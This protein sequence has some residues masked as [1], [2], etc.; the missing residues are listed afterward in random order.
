MITTGVCVWSGTETLKRQKK[1]EVVKTLI[2]RPVCSTNQGLVVEVCLCVSGCANVGASGGSFWGEIWEMQKEC[3]CTSVWRSG[4]CG[5][6]V[7]FPSHPAARDDACDVIVSGNKWEKTAQ[8]LI[9]Y[10]IHVVVTNR[11][12]NCLTRGI[13]ITNA[14]F[15]Y[16]SRSG[17]EGRMSCPCRPSFLLC[18]F[19]KC[20]RRI[21][22]CVCVCVEKK[23]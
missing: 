20:S 4:R 3:M 1:C 19:I 16:C 5:E 7:T 6:R 8:D 13:S 11:A 22:F 18:I 21:F 9:I 2:T 23:L 14:T 10:L 17:N 12:K 15:S